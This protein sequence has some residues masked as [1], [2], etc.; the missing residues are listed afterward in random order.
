MAG[1]DHL[2]EIR[3]CSKFFALT[4]YWNLDSW[5]ATIGVY[6]WR[7][8]EHIE[9]S[10]LINRW[11]KLYISCPCWDLLYFLMKKNNDRKLN[12]IIQIS[13]LLFTP[14]NVLGSVKVWKRIGFSRCIWHW[15]LLRKRFKMCIWAVANSDIHMQM[16]HFWKP[17][18]SDFA[19]KYQW[20]HVQNG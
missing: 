5:N 13:F 11:M 16:V 1:W 3:N 14:K 2:I 18:V 20:K 6:S 12:L 4:R 17:F 10:Q 19:S 7:F 9:N 15:W 8:F